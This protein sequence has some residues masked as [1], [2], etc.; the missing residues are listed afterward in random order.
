[1][2]IGQNIDRI[3]WE[4]FSGDDLSNTKIYSADSLSNLEDLEFTISIYAVNERDIEDIEGLQTYEEISPI[5]EI[6]ENNIGFG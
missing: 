3:L 6:D 5:Q 2:N 4:T 1:M